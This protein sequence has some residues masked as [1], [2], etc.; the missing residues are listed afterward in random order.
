VS[1]DAV[2]ALFSSR[3]GGLGTCER[4]AL[5]AA[6]S[7]GADL[8]LPVVAVAAT[9]LGD[10]EPALKIALRAGC[11]RAV[12]VAVDPAKLDYLDLAR[13]LASAVSAIGPRLILCGDQSESSRRAAVGPA[14]AENL[15]LPHLSGVLAVDVVD[16]VVRCCANLDGERRWFT[17]RLPT[18]LCLRSAGRPGPATRR[19]TGA[20]IERRE[21]SGDLFD[22]GRA[23]QSGG[24]A[25]DGPEGVRSAQSMAVPPRGGA[26]IT[27]SAADLIRRLREDHLLR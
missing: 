13:A 18:V 10:T 17:A 14:V 9:G 8:E 3:R 2:I 20:A 16:G 1:G 7:A 23:G 21:L 4:E 25:P 15:D 26:A 27:E 24:Y 5:R 6:L 11:A 12:A 22:R 19:A